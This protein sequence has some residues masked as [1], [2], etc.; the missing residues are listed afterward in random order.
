VYSICT[1]Q[2][3]SVSLG[4]YIFSFGWASPSFS[5][6]L[7]KYLVMCFNRLFP[8]PCSCSFMIIFVS[9]RRSLQLEFYPK[10]ILCLNSLCRSQLPSCLRRSSAVVCFLGSRVRIPPRACISVLFDC[11]VLSGIL[12][13]RPIPLSKVSYRLWCV[14]ACD[15]ETSRMRRPWP[16]LG[17]CARQED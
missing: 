8:N 11:C 17:C 15:L 13:D 2:V 10:I 3:F 7:Y 16:A 12:C 5:A 9:L 14:I 1:L 4:N 6:K